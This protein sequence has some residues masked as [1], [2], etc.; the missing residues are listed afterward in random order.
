MFIKSKGAYASIP[1]V[2]VLML[3]LTISILSCA[4]I[5]AGG[6]VYSGISD[7]MDYNYESRVSFAYLTT[8]IRQGDNSGMI[9]SEKFH[10]VEVLAVSEEYD[11]DFAV[12]T[13]LYYYDGYIRELFFERGLGL[14]E[15]MA[16]DDG[17]K[18]V[19]AGGFDIKIDGK[20]VT[21]TLT[22]RDNNTYST[23]ISLRSDINND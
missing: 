6:S 5:A 12:C 10:D 14:E 9:T 13:Y 2:F 4:I 19:E 7:D 18:I 11:E 8:K 21:M 20:I 16:L 22:G 3:F 17:D 15:G 1:V 23:K